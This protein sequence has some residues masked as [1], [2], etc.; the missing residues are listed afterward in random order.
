MPRII[1][2]DHMMSNTA[3]TETFLTDDLTQIVAADETTA[4]QIYQ[5]YLAKATELVGT[6]PAASQFDWQCLVEHTDEVNQVAQRPNRRKE[7]AGVAARTS[8]ATNVGPMRLHGPGGSFITISAESGQP[9]A[10]GH[11]P[12]PEVPDSY[13]PPDIYVLRKLGEAAYVEALLRR[14]A[15]WGDGYALLSS[16]SHKLGIVAKG[17]T[18]HIGMATLHEVPFTAETADKQRRALAFSATS[19][20]ILTAAARKHIVLNYPGVAR[21]MYADRLHPDNLAGLLDTLSSGVA[22]QVAI[23]GPSPS[24]HVV[25][26]PD[27]L[28]ADN[29]N[30]DWN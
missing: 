14:G 12:S 29:K 24:A 18:P 15:D 9:I 26:L 2:G 23:Y 21:R 10:A 6:D 22:N 30:V 27:P 5:E 4:D 7:V 1:I 3:K 11:L 8:I 25:V 19:G 28:H 16:I 20:R 13:G 17:K